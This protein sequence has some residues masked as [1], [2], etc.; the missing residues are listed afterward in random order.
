VQLNCPVFYFAGSQDSK[1][2]F[3]NEDTHH[4]LVKEAGH[5]PH[6]THLKK[7]LQAL[8]NCIKIEG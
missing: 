5:N 6:K 3:K 4:I 1:Y 2:C 8:S 7:F